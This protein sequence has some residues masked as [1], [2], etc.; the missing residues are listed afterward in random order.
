[1]GATGSVGASMGMS[2]TTRRSTPVSQV[3]DGQ[4]VICE[5]AEYAEVLVRVALAG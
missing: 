1:M 3:T 2:G 4:L 5:F